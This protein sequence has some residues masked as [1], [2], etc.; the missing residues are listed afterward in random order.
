MAQ[1][2]VDWRNRPE[3]LL[4]MMAAAMPLSFWAWMVLLNNFTIEIASFTGRE[5]GILQ[6]LREIPGFLSFLVVFALLIIAEQR[7]ALLSLILLG[8][9]VAL[10]GYFPSAIGLYITTVISSIGFH[11]YEACNQ[12]LTLQWLDKKTAPSVMGRIYGVAAGAQLLVLGLIFAAYIVQLPEISWQALAQTNGLATSHSSYQLSYL[13]AGLA[14]VIMAVLAWVM[15]PHFKEK[16]YQTRKIILRKRYWLYYALTFIAGAR[17][18]IFIVFAGFLMVEKFGYSVPQI[19]ALFLLNAA[20]NIWFAPI[21]GRVITKIGERA[22]LIFEYVGLIIVFVSYALVNSG[23]VAAGLYVI[24]H[25][26][27]AFAIA[28]KTYF[29]KI[30]DPA[31]MA[32]TASVSFT[33]NHIA[34]VVVPVVF[35]G[36]WL[37][38]PAAV[39]YAGASMAAIS[40]LLSLN[41]PR[42]PGPGEEVVIGHRGQL[43]SAE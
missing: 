24:D 28:I 16:T 11:Y 37:V 26:F 39:F 33:I 10:T 5:I 8:V 13:I 19:T 31:D 2:S 38:S 35:G 34:A 40:L 20:F 12:S 32:S 27:F 21:V 36:L 1:L 15:F 4:M 25:M 3:L 18:Q 22:A 7:L 29:Q 6:S 43:A 42:H 30:A 41:V 9:G 23:L 14:T 17:R